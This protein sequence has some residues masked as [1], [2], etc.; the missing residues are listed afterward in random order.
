M[1]SCI[2][3]GRVRHTRQTPVL[4]RFRYRV[5]MMYLDLD[6]LDSVF[7][8]R[9]FWSTR[10]SALARF[11]RE[12]H[13]GD[14]EQ[15]LDK[16]VRDL[17]RS[18]TGVRPTGPI[19]LLTNLSYFGYCM[20]PV[21]FYYC[22]DDAGDKVVATVC[23]VT[24]TPWGERQM[25]VLPESQAEH[26][27]LAQRFRDSKKM[28]VSPFMPMDIEY[29]WCF[30]RP[31]ERLTVYMANSREGKRFFDASVLLKRTEITGASLARVLSTFPLMT[32]KVIAAIHWEALRLWLKRCPVYM[33]PDKRRK[34]AVH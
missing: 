19:R 12:N 7:E 11:R 25:Y 13:L 4:H 29:D 2:Y 14:A 8:K 23:E 33:H 17:V 10:R 28:H 20:N 6:E 34:I 16:S 31:G 18:E 22:F 26:R 27:G 1:E 9:W 15:P 5:F 32:L 30:T 24:N 21:S 3:E